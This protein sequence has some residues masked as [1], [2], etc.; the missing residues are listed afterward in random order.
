[1]SESADALRA[2][3]TYVS[4]S[5]IP[6]DGLSFEEISLALPD[7]HDLKLDGY[8]RQAHLKELLNLHWS[9]KR[10][11]GELITVYRVKGITDRGLEYLT[12]ARSRDHRQKLTLVATA[13]L[14]ALVGALATAFLS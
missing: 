2:I 9:V 3:L 1:M 6:P 10:A 12:A 5:E 4:E 7:Y 13:I 8:I 11:D 14:S